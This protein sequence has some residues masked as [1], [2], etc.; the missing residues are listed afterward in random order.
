MWRNKKFIIVAVLA[1]VLLFGSLGGAVLADNGDGSTDTVDRS[2]REACREAMLTEAC[3]ILVNDWGCS[4]DITAA[5][6]ENILMTARQAIGNECQGLNNPRGPHGPMTQIFESLG[7]DQEA[8]QAAFEQA[9][10]ELEDGT[11]EGG[12]EAVM[13]RVLEILEIDEE[14]WQAACAEV[15]QAHQ[16]MRGEKPEGRPFGPGFGF[17]GHGGFR[18]M[19]GMR[20]IGGLPCAPWNE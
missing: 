14:E 13:A 1:A 2:Q 15:R 19:G 3:E 7:Y 10:T 11:L 20:G 4:E 12:R 5:D 16:E 9:R 8:V 18:D 17:K 6:L